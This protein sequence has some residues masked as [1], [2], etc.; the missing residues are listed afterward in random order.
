VHTEEG[1]I[2]DRRNRYGK[3]KVLFISLAIIALMIGWMCATVGFAG[4]GSFCQLTTLPLADRTT[5]SARTWILCPNFEPRPPFT[6]RVTID[7]AAGGTADPQPGQDTYPKREPGKVTAIPDSGRSL[8]R[9]LLDG[10]NSGNSTSI[11]ILLK[12]NQ[13]TGQGGQIQGFNIPSSFVLIG[14]LAIIAGSSIGYLVPLGL[15]IKRGKVPANVKKP[16]LILALLSILII[17][18][19]LG[20]TMLAYSGNLNGMFTPSNINKVTNLLSGQGE[21]AMPNVIGACVNLTSQTFGISLN[22][23]NPTPTD[24]TIDALSADLTDHSDGYSLGKISLAKPIV[25][26]PNETVILEL[27]GRLN[28]EAVTRVETAH[29]GV[30]SF[31]VDLSNVNINFAGVN[32]KLN[33]TTTINLVSIMR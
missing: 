21:L 33:G 14:V 18:G 9:L 2:V 28:R 11:E 3:M 29:V 24:L 5:A 20:A 31:G 6:V 13:E 25:A 16:R 12:G 23:T 26:S 4:S 22:F 7:P 10:I 1:P 15:A 32:L 17:A 30:Q 19:P 8:D 27:T